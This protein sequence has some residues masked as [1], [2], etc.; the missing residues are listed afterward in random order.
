VANENKQTKTAPIV[1]DNL[2]CSMNILA[3]Q[4]DSIKFS[5]RLCEYFGGILHG[6]K[7]FFNLV[8][9]YLKTLAL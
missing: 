2:N 7:K 9:P 8:W 5:L 6:F 3:T 4:A 1:L